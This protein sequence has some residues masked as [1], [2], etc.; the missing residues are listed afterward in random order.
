[1]ISRIQPSE[2]NFKGARVNIFATADNHGNILRLPRLLKTL[3]NNAKEIFPKVES[4]STRNV[5]AIVGDW[6]I[7]PSKKGFVTHPELS[8]GDLQNLALIRTIDSVRKVVKDLAVK[9][10]GGDQSAFLSVIYTMGNHCLDA[11]TEFISNVM[12]KNQM[13]SLITNVNLDKSPKMQYLENTVDKVTKAIQYSIPDDK[14]PDLM[15]N[16][17]F[18]S[19]TIPSMDFYNPGL[20]DGLE[21][22]DN[23]NKKDANLTEEDIQGTINVIKEKVDAFKKQNPKG[24]V[25][26][27]SHM[28]GRLSE[29]IQKNVPQINHILNGHDHKNVQSNVGKTSINSLGKDNEMVKALSFE[30]DDNGD[31]IKASMTPYFTETTLSDGLEKHP[32]QLFL[33]EFLEKDLEPL[34]TVGELKSEA[35]ITEGNAKLPAIIKSV[36]EKYGLYDVKM[37]EQLMQNENFKNMIISEANALLEEQESVDKGITTLSYGNEIRYK[38]SY[39][40]NYL[41]S[42]IKRT[43]RSTIDPEIFTVA[44]QSSIVR[45]SLEDGANNLSVMKVFDGVSEDLSNL[46]I[47]KVKGEELVG[48]VVENVLANLKAPTRNTIIHWSD[49]QVNRTLIEDIVKGKSQA[50]YSDAVRVRNPLTKE[51]EPI[52]LQEE[53]KMVIGEK[54]LVKDDIEW[55]GK[56]RD[57]FE[58]LGKTYDQLFREYLESVNYKIHITPKTKEQ[59]IL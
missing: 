35:D 12:R 1:M 49:V 11:G 50:K 31:F 45:G 40:M 54:F 14:N 39:L 37:Q 5:F 29:M 44:I 56:I 24:A 25:I 19:A 55:P 3:E 17:L 57:R 27:L 4:P 26:L 6:F 51:F 23:S 53:Y 15:H 47:G 9:N 58:S 20:C 46:K 43:I 30:F 32:F 10:S 41:T 21:F 38:N 34:I 22:Y 7:N 48:L 36:L 42:A 28:G 59:R 33:N 52:D 13:T 16:I 18:L 2:P 8:N